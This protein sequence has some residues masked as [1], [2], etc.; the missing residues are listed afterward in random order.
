MINIQVVI[1]CNR[2]FVGY[3]NPNNSGEI[4]HRPLLY[5]QKKK[6]KKMNTQLYRIL[7]SIIY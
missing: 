3:D 7:N 6:K 1:I 5:I 2:L 4:I